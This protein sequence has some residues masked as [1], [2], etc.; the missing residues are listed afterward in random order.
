MLRK[1]TLAVFG[2]VSSS[3]SIA[4]MPGP[5]KGCVADPVTVPCEARLW[6]L[7]VQALY[8]ESAYDADYGYGNN[9]VNG[10]RAVDDDGD[11]GFRLE[12][13]YHFSTGNDITLTWIHYDN[14]HQQNGFSGTIPITPVLFA[15]NVP[16]ALS[17]DNRFDQ[18][19]LVMGQ[20]SDFGKLKNIRFYG[21]FQYAD[22]RLDAT[23]IFQQTP[24]ALVA[25]G[26]QSVR[27][28]HNTDFNGVG[29][30][31][32]ID[33][34]YNLNSNFSV[35]AN[36]AASILFGTGRFNDGFLYSNNLITGARYGSKK[37]M[38]PSLE[39]KLGA[40]YAYAS[41][42]GVFNIQGGYQAVNYFN[43]LQARGLNPLTALPANSDYGLY[44]PYFGVKW[45]GNA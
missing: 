22:I 24:A 15:L 44:G 1:V 16:Y 31:I 12:G 27:Q 30:V 40:N 29:P 33:F 23:N 41:D 13:S 42:Y 19:N 20:H 45:I 6:D 35:V 7:G 4:G 9:L 37:M 32:G 11:W 34:S 25:N 26:V 10:Y 8:L 17:I 18:V 36:S 28:F 39:A 5:M 3:V 38:V 21:G 2:L 43:A 14:E